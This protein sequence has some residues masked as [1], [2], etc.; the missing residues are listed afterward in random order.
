MALMFGW[1]A[2]TLQTH[3]TEIEAQLHHLQEVAA[4]HRRLL[5]LLSSSGVTIAAL[6]GTEYAPAATA[7]V[8]WDTQRGEWTVISHNLPALPPNKAYQLW[9]LTPDGAIPS[10][11]FRLDP[12]G[13]GIIQAKLPANRTDIAGAAVSLE[14]VGGVPQPTGHIVLAGKF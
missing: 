6:A 12:Q 9:F 7:R 1:F 11:T 3:V 14:P 2:R 10:D 5:S 4:Q 8:L 13:L